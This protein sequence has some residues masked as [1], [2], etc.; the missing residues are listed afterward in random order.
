MRIGDDKVNNESGVDLEE[1]GL[2]PDSQALFQ[3][4]LSESRLY[5]DVTF[6]NV[7]FSDFAHALSPPS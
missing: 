1:S 6:K 2:A 7:P 3:P 5:R 4:F